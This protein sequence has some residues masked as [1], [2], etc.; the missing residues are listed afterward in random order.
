MALVHFTAFTLVQSGC[1]ERKCDERLELETGISSES[2][3]SLFV[4]KSQPRGVGV[5]NITYNWVP[6]TREKEG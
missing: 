3:L 5:S 6:Y 2:V 4:V 1:V